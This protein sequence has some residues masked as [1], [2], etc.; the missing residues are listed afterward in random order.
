VGSIG[1]Y[2]GYAAAACTTLSFVPQ[3]WKIIREKKTAGISLAM[4]AI[5]TFGLALWLA[6]GVLTHSVPLCIAN[7]VTLAL[8]AVI[9]GMK[10]KLG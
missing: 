3:A 10:I 1:E 9:L 8:A 6:Y 7:S 4:Y 5:F 2:L